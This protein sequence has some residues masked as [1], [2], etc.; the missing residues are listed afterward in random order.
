MTAPSATTSP[1]LRT[2]FDVRQL[3]WKRV[4]GFTIAA[5]G[6]AVALS[7]I[8][9][10]TLIMDADGLVQSNRVVAAVPYEAHIK[11]I[12]ARSGDYVHAGD[13]IAI[14]ESAT[15]SRNLADLAVQRARLT[16]TIAHLE[17]RRQVVGAL[18]PIAKANGSRLQALVADLE[19][20]REN[21]M[22]SFVHLQQITAE[23]YTALEK[24]ATLQ[25]EGT[26][27]QEELRQNRAA[28][29]QTD[30]SYEDLKSMYAN[31]LLLAPTSGVVGAAVVDSGE[32]LPPGKKVLE[33]YAGTPFV[34]AY[35]SDS[36]FVG[37][38]EGEQVVVSRAGM[39]SRGTV[40]KILPLT[41]ALPPEF[42]KPVRAR[43]R[44]QLLRIA[45]PDA[46]GFVTDQKVRVTSCYVAG[47]PDFASA[48]T[49][50][51]R[52]ISDALR[53]GYARVVK[54]VVQG[55]ETAKALGGRLLDQ[56]REAHEES[57]GRIE[58]TQ[59]AD[60]RR[61][62]VGPPT[63]ETAEFVSRAVL[64]D[65]MPRAYA[66][67]R[68]EQSVEVAVAPPSAIDNIPIGFLSLHEA[69]APSSEARPPSAEE[70]RTS[71]EEASTPSAEAR[72]PS[73]EAR[74]PSAE[75]RA[76]TAEARALTAEARALTVEGRAEPEVQAPSLE[77]AVRLE[78]QPT[79]TG[80]DA[81]PPPTLP[82]RGTQHS[83]ASGDD[84]ACLP[85]AAA[86]RQDHPRGWPS[87]T[88]RAPGHE[89]K[90]CWRAT[91]FRTHSN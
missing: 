85:S 82:E 37:I 70:A 48:T 61:Q 68:S 81:R 24:L 90:I 23:A 2:R 55:L 35:R 56:M 16:T 20:A 88:L 22:T 9:N 29:A 52:R 60:G 77:A 89:G 73:A 36:S 28:L 19:R 84:S 74:A 4:G 26:S 39:S 50:A 33:I 65:R 83:A 80:V 63:S 7:Y 1:L 49:N 14:V 11:Q 66:I 47:C 78:I 31:G 27:L 17:S 3:S 57:P 76:L 10:N 46:D 8:G 87:W 45:L 64:E 30:A 18:L 5:G 71:T 53:A 79:E 59:Q 15:T 41:E 21:G 62:D 54:G 40:E 86:V 38:E 25:A 43:D 12:F 75:A 91:R 42:Q 69:G 13:K 67:G 32:V 51:A 72:T 6:L 44:G 34:L 58:E